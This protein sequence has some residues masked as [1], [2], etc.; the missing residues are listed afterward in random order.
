MDGDELVAVAA[1]PAEC[2]RWVL[3]CL[4]AVIGLTLI[5]IGFGLFDYV[6][7]LSDAANGV[8]FVSALCTLLGLLIFSLFIILIQ[9]WYRGNPE[10]DRLVDSL[11]LLF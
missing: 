10:G 6:E 5:V 1:E 4:V 9:E 7:K 2:C 3:M 11:L 8:L